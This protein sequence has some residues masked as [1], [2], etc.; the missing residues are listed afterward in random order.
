MSPSHRP[1]GPSPS[2]RGRD[3][4]SPRQ[5]RPGSSAPVSGEPDA[6]FC[7]LGADPGW[8]TAYAVGLSLSATSE[9]QRLAALL[10]V[11]DGRPELLEAAHDHLMRARVRDD[12]PSDEALALIDHALRRAHEDAA[13]RQPRRR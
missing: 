2:P 5:L 10:D 9:D 7:P 13:E 8:L 3:R 1:P 12:G 11:T 4:T 6:R